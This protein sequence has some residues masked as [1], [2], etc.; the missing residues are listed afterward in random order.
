MDENY[1][2]VM[3]IFV[4]VKVEAY[5][6]SCHWNQEMWTYIFNDLCTLY[7]VPLIAWE[8]FVI[9]KFE[10]CLFSCHWNQD[11]WLSTLRLACLVVIEIMI[12]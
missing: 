3:L 8:D 1:T 4:V 5:M 12:C 10:A 11:L 6:F 7:Q 2:C 9:V